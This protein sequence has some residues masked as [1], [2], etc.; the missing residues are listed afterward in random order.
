MSRARELLHQERTWCRSC[1]FSHGRISGVRSTLSPCLAYC[2]KTRMSGTKCENSHER[3]Q[4]YIW[5]V[6]LSLGFLS[7]KIKTYNTC[8]VQFQS[9]FF[10]LFQLCGVEVA[11]CAASYRQPRCT[12]RFQSQGF[13]THHTKCSFSSRSLSSG[14]LIRT[15]PHGSGLL[16]LA[17]FLVVFP[18]A[19]STTSPEVQMYT[20]VSYKSEGRD[21]CYMQSDYTAA[22]Q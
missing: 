16:H 18:S 21:S 6:K 17:D 3:H 14:N 2:A 22:R 12:S 10:H 5:T 1:E 13:S 11:I 7:M 4:V 9:R 19:T 8:D 20:C 15:A